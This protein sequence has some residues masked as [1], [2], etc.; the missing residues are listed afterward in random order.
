MRAEGQEGV[1]MRQVPADVHT[2]R[3]LRPYF[4]F[5]RERKVPKESDYFKSCF[6]ATFFSKRK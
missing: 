6:F 5:G 4:S 2:R 1:G 3:A